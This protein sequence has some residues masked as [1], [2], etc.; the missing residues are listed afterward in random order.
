MHE[1]DAFDSALFW[2]EESESKDGY[3]RGTN[4]GNV[5]TNYFGNLHGNN[6]FHLRRRR[7]NKMFIIPSPDFEGVMME[8]EIK[9]SDDY[10]TAHFNEIERKF[11]HFKFY[12]NLG[13]G[14][15]CNLE[16]GGADWIKDNY[17]PYL[18]TIIGTFA[19]M[20][21]GMDW[22]WK[23]VDSANDYIKGMLLVWN[24]YNVRFYKK[25]EA[26]VEDGLGDKTD[27]VNTF[28]GDF[29]YIEE[30][31]KLVKKYE[32]LVEYYVDKYPDEIKF[33]EK[34]KLIELMKVYPYVFIPHRDCILKN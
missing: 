30:N 33:T 26:L 12:F 10:L 5:I 18:W 27:Y 1:N 31:E 29:H 25:L 32:E 23:S 13:D 28:L 24:K 34:D 22:C 11:G 17:D 16:I 20:N 19:Y 2:G 21:F 9:G 7:S 15:K 3:D 8:L 4:G 14:T 6:D